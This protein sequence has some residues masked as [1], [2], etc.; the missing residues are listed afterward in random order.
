MK[1]D[2]KL[3]MESWRRKS[4]LTEGLSDLIKNKTL[5][6]DAIEKIGEKLSDNEGFDLAVQ[7]FTALSTS[8]H[9]EVEGL[10]EGPVDWINSKVVQGLIAKEKLV[11]TLKDDPRFKPVLNLGA[12]AL[13]L[14][15][16]YFKHKS[17]GIN[18]EDFAS[19]T[20][21]IAKG[22]SIELES[23]ADAALMENIKA[24]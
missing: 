19:A 12:P 5:D 2:M 21:M 18:P 16:L 23:L 3:I 1:N 4:I 20:E 7:L 15:F 6:N 22:G 10:E 11:D 14:A 24:L 8:D 13:A 9:E 17:G